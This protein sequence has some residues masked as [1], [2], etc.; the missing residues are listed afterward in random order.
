MGSEKLNKGAVIEV[1]TK[2]MQKKDGK[3]NYNG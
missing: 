2:M 3:D 1:I